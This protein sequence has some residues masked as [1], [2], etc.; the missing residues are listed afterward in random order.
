MTLFEVAPSTE[1]NTGV[2]CIND[3]FSVDVFDKSYSII[4]LILSTIG[5]VI[6]TFI[7]KYIDLPLVLW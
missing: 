4:N 6:K 3:K 5:L 7:Y 1:A 2:S